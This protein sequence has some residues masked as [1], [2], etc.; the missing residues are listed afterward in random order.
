MI[1]KVIFYLIDNVVIPL[2]LG[3]TACIL[4]VIL[5]GLIALPVIVMFLFD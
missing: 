4:V 3:L 2:L 1:K 5:A